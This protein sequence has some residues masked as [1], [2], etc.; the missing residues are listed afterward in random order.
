MA[1]NPRV[2]T[3]Q[4]FTLRQHLR[5]ILQCI[6]CGQVGDLLT[7]SNVG[8]CHFHLKQASKHP[9]ATCVVTP[10][11]LPLTQNSVKIH[12]IIKTHAL[13]PS[14]PRPTWHV[15]HTPTKRRFSVCMYTPRSM[16]WPPGTWLDPRLPIAH[17]HSHL[18]PREGV[19][20]GRKHIKSSVIIACVILVLAF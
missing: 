3:A 6:R 8:R 20:Y 5:R 14:P 11:R 13:F 4:V 12:V 19:R 7:T 1:V 18:S 10:H 2:V 16:A 17:V 15:T 9:L